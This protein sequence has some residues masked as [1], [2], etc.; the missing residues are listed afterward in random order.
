MLFRVCKYDLQQ[1]CVDV[2]NPPEPPRT[3]QR[4]PDGPCLHVAVCAGCHE[5]AA[6]NHPKLQP[7][8]ALIDPKI[9]ESRWTLCH[10]P[11]TRQHL[12]AQKW[13]PPAERAAGVS[14]AGSIPPEGRINL[15]SLRTACAMLT[16]LASSILLQPLQTSQ[17]PGGVY[18]QARLHLT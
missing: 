13:R 8:T 3:P 6:L 15:C 14:A 17:L 1:M 12:S 11:N 9:C 4:C 10:Q 2:S 16:Q 7:L 5:A 18:I